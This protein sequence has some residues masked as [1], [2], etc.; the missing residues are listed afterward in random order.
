V[1][2]RALDDVWNRVVA[3]LEL[4]SGLRFAFIEADNEQVRTNLRRRLQR[5]LKAQGKSL[6]SPSAKQDVLDWLSSE[7]T[8]PGI[9]ET[10]EYTRWLPLPRSSQERFVLH[11]LNEGRD[12]LRRHLG[13]V[14]F[15]IGSRG[16]LQRAGNEAP[17][18]WSMRE[19]ALDLDQASE[20]HKEAASVV[21]AF[22]AQEKSAHAY[23]V[24]LSFSRYDTEVAQSLRARLEKDGLRVFEASDNIVPGGTVVGRLQYLAGIRYYVCILSPSYIYSKSLADELR[25]IHLNQRAVFPNRFIPVMVRDTLMPSELRH[26]GYVDFRT[27]RQIE[28]NYP[29]LLETLKQNLV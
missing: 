11:R 24:Y 7:Q 10:P 29:R 20:T 25:W 22:K 9:G 13:G 3:T 4:G 1:T 6:R 23:D 28:A 21:P 15:L 8:A 19:L 14:L 26:L 16:M 18:L 5:Y 17:D 2:Q 12:N 27:T